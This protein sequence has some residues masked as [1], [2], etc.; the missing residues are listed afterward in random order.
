MNEQTPTTTAPPPATR[1]IELRGV[2]V[3][4]LRGIDIDIPLKQLVVITGV[5]GSGK[6]SLAFDTLYAEGQRRYIESFSAYARQFLDRLDKPDADRIDHIPPAIAIRQSSRSRSG[7]STVA[8]ATEVYDFL[9]LLYAKIGRLFCPDCNVPVQRHTTAEICQ[10]INS[11]PLKT[12]FQV[13]FPV[14]AA[15]SESFDATIAGLLEAGFTRCIVAGQT[16]NLS[17]HPVGLA[18]PSAAALIVVD[19]L[20]AGSAST[21]RLADSIETAMQRGAGECV[22]LIAADAE[23]PSTIA[24]DGKHWQRRAFS[25]GLRCEECGREFES[26]QPSTFSFNSP[27]GACPQC[28]GFGSVSAISWEKLVPNPTLTLQQGAI[29]CWTTPAYE[30]EWHELLAL[31]GDYDIPVDIPFADLTDDQVQRIHDGVPERNFGGMVGFFR[32]LERRKYKTSVAVF[33]NRWRSYEP[34]PSCRGARLNPT[35]LAVR[36]G[37]KNIAQFCAQTVGQAGKWLDQVPG[38]TSFDASGAAVAETIFV[39]LRARLRYLNDVGLHYLTLDRVMRTLSGG[40][41][42]RVALTAALGS[43]L[44]NALYVLDEPTAG[45]HPRD[46]ERLI[47]AIGQLQRAGNSVVVV[48]HDEAFMR[49]ADQLIDIGPAAGRNGGHLVFQGPPEE[50]VAVEDSVT[51]D[52]LSGRQTVS[53]I[54]Q[55]RAQQGTINLRNAHLHNLKHIDVD[56][57]LGMLC[58][59]TGVS[60]SGKSTLVQQTLYPAI[61]RALGQAS[62]TVPRCDDIGDIEAIDEVIQVDQNPVGRSSRSNPVTYLKAFDEIRKSFAATAEAKVRNFTASHFSFN[63]AQGGRCPKCQGAGAVEIDMQFL[64]DVTMTCPDCRGTRFRREILGVKYRGRSIAEVLN[65]T[66]GEAFA[67]FRGKR[68]LQKQLMFLRDVG[69]D[70]LPLGQPANTLSGGES[71]RLKLAAHLSSGTKTRTLFLLD[72]PTTGLHAADIVKLLGCFEAL[73]DAGHSLIVVEHNLDVIRAADHLIDLG[74]DAGDGGGEVVATGPPAVV[75]GVAASLTGRY[76]RKST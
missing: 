36:I 16:V 40:E 5:S 14:I 73:L 44:V 67:F 52:F 13:C 66:V 34:C 6:S 72:E 26:P 63:S 60:G 37:E 56:F 68:K 8:T 38:K 15:G 4:N 55:K 41:A 28:Q 75:A 62:T 25:K 54:A 31:A 59:V 51:G 48:E 21:A 20:S 74:P 57:P 23:T 47:D 61:C 22:L 11:L 39:Q 27:L 69:L 64:P 58:V 70:Y 32:W 3:H 50:I 7:R 46:T 18:E 65:M 49:A 1:A 12:R 53:L 76:L 35:A 45:L 10:Q 19:R 42:Q 17:D 33:L 29:A 24:V 71:Q 30:H 9:R 43:S 2:R